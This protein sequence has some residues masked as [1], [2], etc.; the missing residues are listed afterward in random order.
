MIDSFT[1]H[2]LGNDQAASDPPP[3][4]RCPRR[5]SQDITF[6]QPRKEF[7]NELSNRPAV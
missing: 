4:L 2:P 7:G 5:S 1:V 3:V 6:N